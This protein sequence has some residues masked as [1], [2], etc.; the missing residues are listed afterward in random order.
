MQLAIP[1]PKTPNGRVYRFSPNE[2]AHPR[3]FVLGD[4]PQDF[5]ITEAA[6]ARMKLEPRSKQMVCPYSSTVADESDFTHP[7]DVKAALKVVEHA[8]V[9]DIEAELARIFGSVNRSQSRNSL[10]RIEAK[11][12]QSPRPTPRFSR[13]DL[14]R[15]LA[16]DHCGRAY[17]VFAIGLF[18][19][20]CG[21]PNLRLHFAREADLVRRQVELANAQTEANHELAYRLL[22]NAHED[23]LTAFEA[24]LKTVYLYG[25][26]RQTADGVIAKPVRNDFQNV[27]LAQGRLSEFGIDP[28]DCLNGEQLAALKLNIQK[29]HIIGH[30]LGV[31]DAKFAEHAEDARVGETVHI[32]GE[33]V[34]LFAELGQRVVNELDSWL[35]GSAAPMPLAAI[36]ASTDEVACETSGGDTVVATSRMGELGLAPI[37]LRLALWIAKQSESGLDADFV[38][39]TELLNDFSDASLRDLEEAVA[40]LELD[41]FITSVVSGGDLPHIKPTLD[42]FATFDP[43]V[44][45]HDPTHDAAEFAKLVLEGEEDV[46][47]AALHTKCEWPERRFNPAIGLLVSQIDEGHVSGSYGTDYPTHSFHVSPTDR[48]RLKRFIARVGGE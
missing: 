29:R 10:V 32:V 34:C 3:H 1:L 42:L 45:G 44:T 16:C 22:G 14:L 33:E 47:V 40:E 24:T 48:V 17:G 41:G 19:P 12:R 7:E 39:D 13:N 11:V 6:R 4:A 15:D 18:C 23:V 38:S 26:S 28:F 9:S 46:D 36:P 2:Q 8:A 27:E 30:N 31:M 37:A 43:E 5:V 35:A 21:A 25:V 20:D